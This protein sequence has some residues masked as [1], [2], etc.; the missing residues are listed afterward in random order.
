MNI[1]FLTNAYPDFDTSYRGIFIQK[2]ATLLQNEGYEI[3]VVTP[4]VFR[5]SPHFEKRSGIK[6]Y[7]FPFF[8]RNRLLIE[9]RK[10]PYLRM[11]LYY[12]TGFFLT[13]YAAFRNRCRLIHAHWAFQQASMVS[14]LGYRGS[15]LVTT[16]GL[17]SVW[18]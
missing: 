15:P 18:L 11:L 8:S 17:T 14:G 12:V 13:L 5:N 10:V 9:Y 1:L 7:R 4:K 6:V 16:T 3:S 2:M